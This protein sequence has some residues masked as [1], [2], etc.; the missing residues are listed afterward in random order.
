MPPSM[1]SNLGLHYLHMSHKKDA[2]FIRL[3][4][5]LD[6][7]DFH[8]TQVLS[9]ASKHIRDFGNYRIGDKRK[10]RVARA[11]VARTYPLVPLDSCTS[12]FIK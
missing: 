6:L 2:R 12:M 5:K 4:M 7:S 9:R 3:E 8:K 1:T 10:L 11:F